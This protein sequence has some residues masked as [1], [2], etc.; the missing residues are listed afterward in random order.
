MFCP[1]NK[2][3]TRFNHSS[4]VKQI[5]AVLPNFA[6]T[7]FSPHRRSFDPKENVYCG[8]YGVMNRKLGFV[9]QWVLICLLYAS[10]IAR[11]SAISLT[12][13]AV[14]LCMIFRAV[15]REMMTP[16]LNVLA[17]LISIATIAGDVAVTLFGQN[18]P[19]VAI[20]SNSSGSPYLDL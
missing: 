8:L 13:L 2:Q 16:L 3:Y 20:L 14:T 5:P 11:S 6:A 7:L 12:N 9:G 19:F 10:S 17:L 4:S 15:T 1:A 18:V